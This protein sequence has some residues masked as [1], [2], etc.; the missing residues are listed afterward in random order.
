MMMRIP[1]EK[2]AY[3]RALY[4]PGGFAVA[5][6]AVITLSVVVSSVE[7]FLSPLN[8]SDK[9]AA[10]TVVLTGAGFLLA[11]LAAVVAILAYR[12]AARQPKLELTAHLSDGLFGGPIV[13]L[14]AEDKSLPEP[15]E[16]ELRRLSSYGE[17]PEPMWPR[18]YDDLLTL[19]IGIR[20]LSSYTARNPAVRI[21]FLGLYGDL[22]SPVEWQV[23]KTTGRVLVQWEGGAD[24]AVHGN[25]TRQLPPLNLIGMVAEKSNPDWEV[26]APA[27]YIGDE[28]IV[29]HV[30]HALLIE[31]VAEGFRKLFIVEAKVFN[32][33]GWRAYWLAR[34]PRPTDARED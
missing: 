21:E 25:W 14:I 8:L 23:L 31:V 3:F 5:L 17:L 6:L 12:L 22:E 16:G 34:H 28:H 19:Q 9:L 7:V 18:E 1:K 29:A 24:Y 30:Q 2:R 26:D 4:H 20:N 32:E 15:S 33:S 11:V 10:E 27:H 13:F